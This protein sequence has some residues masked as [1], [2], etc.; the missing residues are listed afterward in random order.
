MWCVYYK[1]LQFVI[2]V[3]KLPCNDL[4]QD[5]LPANG[6]CYKTFLKD[7]LQVFS[8]ETIA[9]I[10]FNIVCFFYMKI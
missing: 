6:Q 7:E 5:L 4:R 2:H 9:Q 1:E 8:G 3:K 10:Q